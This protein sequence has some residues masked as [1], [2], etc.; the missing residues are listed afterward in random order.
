MSSRRV[1]RINSE[2]QKDFDDCP[3]AS[4]RSASS[5]GATVAYKFVEAKAAG[6]DTKVCTAPRVEDKKDCAVAPHTKDSEEK[7]GMLCSCAYPRT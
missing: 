1:A 5:D 6:D 4:V 2:A 7:E 3:S